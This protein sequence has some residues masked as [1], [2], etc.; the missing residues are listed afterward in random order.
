MIPVNIKGTTLWA[1]LD[2]GSSRNFISSDAVRKLKLTPI[3]HE[4]RQIVTLS[5][6]TKQSLPIFE[7]TMTSL[8][9]K[10]RERVELTGSK[11][12]DFTT[13]LRPKLS[14]LK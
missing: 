4:T 10:T 9:G 13:V 6:T 7:V 1:Y 14:Y 8:E 5:G 2:S 12:S 3:R 11:M